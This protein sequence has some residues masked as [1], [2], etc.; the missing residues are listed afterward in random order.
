MTRSIYIFIL[1]MMSVSAVVAKTRDELAFFARV[2]CEKERLVEGDSCLVSYVIYSSVPPSK[3]EC[4]SSLKLK[5]A[6]IRPIRF[7]REAT[8]RRVVDNGRVVYR[9]VWAQ[10]MVCPRKKGKYKLTP[11]HFKANFTYYRSDDSSGP[12]YF[13]R[14]PK[15]VSTKGKADTGKQTIL[16]TE[17]PR[18]TTI[19]IMESGESIF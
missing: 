10:Y 2:H 9:M 14:T 12:A 7:N 15:A 6:K 8:L 17:P 18:R 19:E 13:Y 4:K 3:V 16:V 5:D 1:A 11:F